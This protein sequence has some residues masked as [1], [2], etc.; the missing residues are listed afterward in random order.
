MGQTPNP[1]VLRQLIENSGTLADDAEASGAPPPVAAPTVSSIEAQPSASDAT[2][3]EE[4]RETV[5]RLRT[6]LAGY[7]RILAENAPVAMAIF[8]RDMRYLYANQRWLEVFRL[9]QTEIISRS[10]YDVFPSLHPGWRHV[11]ERALSGQVVRSDRDTVDH[12]GQPM[13]YRWEVRPWRHVDTTVG[14]LMITCICVA[15]MRSRDA[16]EGAAAS[17]PNPAARPA[18]EGVWSLPLPLVALDQEGRVCR[19]GTV[20][21][22]MFLAAGLREGH[23]HFWQLFA[24]CSAGHDLREPTMAALQSVF[25]GKQSSAVVELPFR[26]AAG[27]GLPPAH[28]RFSK[29]SAGAAGVAQDSVLA[30]GLDIPPG[31]GAG[32]LGSVRSDS[33]EL[34]AIRSELKEAEDAVAVSRVREARL[35]SVLDSIPCGLLL[36]DERGRAVFHNERADALLGPPALEGQAVEEWLSQSCR[37]EQHKDEVVRQWREGVWRKQLTR[38]VSIIAEDGLLRDVELRPA[39]LPGSGMLVMV[40]DVTGDRR[41]EELLRATEAK[42]RTIVHENPLPI[43]LTDRS[44]LVFEANAAAE[45]MLGRTRPELRRLP[46]EEWFAP[47]SHAARG[48]ALRDMAQRGDLFANVSVELRDREGQPVPASLRIATVPDAQGHAAATVHFF[49]PMEKT[50]GASIFT[51]LDDMPEAPPPVPVVPPGKLL[52][53]TDAHGR[54][55]QW[56]E[57]AAQCFGLTHDEALGRG[58]HSL[59]RPSDASG[60]YAD[61][62]P[63]NEGGESRPVEWNFFH[64]EHGRM[65]SRFVLIPQ[66]PGTLS[67][68]LMSENTSPVERKSITIRIAPKPAAGAPVRL[69]P[70]PVSVERERMLLGE[71][72]HRVKNH[73]QIITS[74]LNLQLSTLNHDDAKEALRSSQNRV[75]SIAALHQHLY[76]LAMGEAGGFAEFASGLIAHL[77]EC[78]EVGE[79]RVQVELSVPTEAVPEEWLMPLALS[80]NEM[81]SNA[82]KHAYGGG[83]GG[84]LKI[85]LRL[86]NSS[87]DLTVRDDGAGMPADFDDHRT[88]GLGLKIMRVFAG[89]LGGDVRVTSDPGKGASFHLH[90]PLVSAAG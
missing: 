68:A 84:C 12:A 55:V 76:A 8:D 52:L 9:E 42:F 85:G 37:D 90:F 67:V 1:S 17:V 74:M 33:D 79:D 23:T 29:I 31:G 49:R 89:Q 54:V 11:Y 59:F 7:L 46:L 47:D 69:A 57:A 82:F 41:S 25:S 70:A 21:A 13:L 40:H 77:R 28:W 80:L 87:G 73:L 30:I 3:R 48:A 43:V 18:Q 81:V 10:Q 62:A 6:G 15:G 86:E 26:V 38:T 20:A 34:A 2:P 75:R 22:E 56:S 16:A 64:P 14:G 32:L 35:R 5:P 83:R 45:A 66:E 39:S 53:S 60:F 36:L 24:G 51:P 88:T 4:A 63:L 61:L 50:S 78:Y 27:S 72:H 44:G 71:T 65:K 58:L 19:A